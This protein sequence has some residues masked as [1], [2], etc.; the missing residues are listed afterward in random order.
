M[1]PRNELRSNRYPGGIAADT[2]GSTAISNRVCRQIA[3][4]ICMTTGEILASIPANL[5]CS[6]LFW[7]QV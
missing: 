5:R 2:E 7:H 4:C 6:I 1:R 3:R